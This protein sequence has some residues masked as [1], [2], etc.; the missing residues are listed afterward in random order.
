MLYLTPN[1][2]ISTFNTN[3]TTTSNNTINKLSHKQNK[4]KLKIKNNNKHMNRIESNLKYK[5]KKTLPNKNFKKVTQVS[6]NILTNN[7]YITC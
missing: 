2:V 7:P 6:K 3:Q 4:K 1:C 5:T